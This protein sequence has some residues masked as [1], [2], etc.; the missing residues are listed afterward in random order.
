MHHQVL[1]VLSLLFA[2]GLLHVLS[3][4]LRVSFPILLVLGGLAISLIPGLPEIRLEPDLVFL[5]FLPPLLY[6]SAWDTSWH[7]F[8]EN[9]R[10][11][12][13]QAVGLV[14][15]TSC[16][17]ALLGRALG[18]PWAWGFLLG[19]IIS[20]PDAVAAAS[21]FK[22]LRVPKSALVILEGE[23]LINDA[24]SL[25]V[26]RFALATILTGRFS[27]GEAALQFVVVSVVGVAIGLLLAR[28]VFWIHQHLPLSAGVDAALT[29]MTPYLM[30]L[31]AEQVHCSGVLAVVAGGL[32]LSFRAHEFLRPSSRVQANGVWSTL[33]FLLNGLVFILIGLQLPMMVGGLGDVPVWSAIA[34]GLIVSATVIVVRIGWTFVSAYIMRLSPAR[35]R[36]Q[37]LPPDPR[38][39]F[40]VAWSG[41]RGVVS[42]ASA[43]SIP[44]LLDSGE[45][46]PQRA[47]CLFITFVVILS[48]LVLQGLSLPAIIRWLR[49]EPEGEPHEQRSRLELLLARAAAEHLRQ[50]YAR[51]VAQ[52]STFARLLAH[53]DELTAASAPA[54]EEA[55]YR[56]ARRSIVAVQRLTLLRVQREATVEHELTLDRALALDLEAASLEDEPD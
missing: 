25:I 6:E 32:Y 20:P 52:Q 37:P 15:F 19:G 21:V 38:V 43:L 9:R 41:M 44:L 28:V 7:D 31:I 17:T 1:L 11:I 35:R 51:E 8:W 3:S 13:I 53:Y 42:L 56:E 34:Y 46:F 23:S 14:F 30:Y 50:K 18:F 29:V 26:F 45:P 39:V 27:A 16:V 40:L 47:L 55:R 36:A 33:S 4:K 12:F 5:V 24:S 49:F 2:I 22:G 54:S 10:A 48:T